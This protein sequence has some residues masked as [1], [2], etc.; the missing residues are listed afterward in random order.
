MTERPYRALRAIVGT[1]ILLGITGLWAAG[2]LGVTPPLGAM[3]DVVVLGIVIAG[4]HAVYGESTMSAAMDDAQ[5]FTNPGSDDDDD[6]DVD[7]ESN[8]RSTVAETSDVDPRD[9]VAEHLEAGE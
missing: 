5:E 2:K 4:G 6:G 8:G 7:P 3:W 1:T 9:G